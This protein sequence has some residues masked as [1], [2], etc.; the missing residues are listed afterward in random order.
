MSS[1]SR[2]LFALLVSIGLTACGGG[3]NNTLLNPTGGTETSPDTG[4]DPSTTPD[5]IDPDTNALIA[6]L[7]PDTNVVLTN[8][9]VGL[10]IERYEDTK[11]EFKLGTTYL[12]TLTSPGDMKEGMP[13]EAL[14]SYKFEACQEKNAFVFDGQ[15]R[16]DNSIENNVQVSLDLDNIAANSATLDLFDVTWDESK[17][18]YT[19]SHQLDAAQNI[20]TSTCIPTTY[21]LS[22]QS[23]VAVFPVN[24]RFTSITSVNTSPSFDAT[25]KRLVTWEYDFFSTDSTNPNKQYTIALYDQTLLDSLNF[26]DAVYAL[27]NTATDAEKAAAQAGYTR[28]LTDD[29][30]LWQETLSAAATSFE[31]P[32]AVTLTDQNNYLL[33][34]VAWESMNET[35]ATP[36]KIYYFSSRSFT[37]KL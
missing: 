14:T 7:T 17:Y 3:G 26:F 9:F 30:L 37:Y 22:L 11:T 23:N 1:P 33:V 20:T 18:A 36:S 25:N 13:F 15:M 5:T 19:G 2:L 35:K 24:N 10:F 21:P 4:T 27:P 12:R 28:V 32:A 29:V 8:R 34:V 31:I 6:S 16:K